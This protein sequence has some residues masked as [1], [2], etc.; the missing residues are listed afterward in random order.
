MLQINWQPGK[1]DLTPTADLTYA[2][3]IG[4]APGKGDIFYACADEQGHRLNL[5]PGNMEYNLD[6]TLNVSGWRKGDYYIAV[7]TIDAMGKGSA[8]SDAAVYRHEVAHAPFYIADK[9]I[10]TADT[11]IMGYDGPAD[12]SLRYNWDLDG[13]TIISSEASGSILK[14]VF[15]NRDKSTSR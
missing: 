9:D 12:P 2:L 3:R 15:D 1:D 5:M 8:W 4:T 10:T 6:K 7:Q 11:A 13:G 14:V